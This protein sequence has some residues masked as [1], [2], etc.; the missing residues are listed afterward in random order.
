VPIKEKCKKPKI[1][2]R[3]NDDNNLASVS[4]PILNNK[5]E[6]S[7]NVILFIYYNPSVVDNN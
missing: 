1:L 7:S 6:C 4:H 2:G 5:E 3:D